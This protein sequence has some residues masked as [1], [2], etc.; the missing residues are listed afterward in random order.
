MEKII[1]VS[2]ICPEGYE[3]DKEKSTI[4]N[5]VFKLKPT[6]DNIYRELFYDNRCYYLDS[7]GG[8]QHWDKGYGSY[9]SFNNCTSEK[10]AKKLLAINQLMNVAKYLNGD[11]KPDWDNDTAFKY[12]IV[13]NADKGNLEIKTYTFICVNAIYFKTKE[14]AQR[15]IE[16]LGEETIKLA[17]STDW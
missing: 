11:W 17:L 3:L 12:T 2:S 16:I 10:Q 9:N 8:V 5:L 15:A 4:E 7:C 1:Q 14:L 13:Y 6:V